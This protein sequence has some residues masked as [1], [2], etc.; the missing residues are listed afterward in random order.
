MQ[1]LSRKT[2]IR[3]PF[4]SSSRLP[5]TPW[6]SK[7]TK[8]TEH[9]RRIDC[10]DLGKPFFILPHRGPRR[11][12]P[13]N[14]GSSGRLKE[15]PKWIL[16]HNLKWGRIP[17]V[18]THE[19]VGS[20]LQPRAQELCTL[21]VQ[22]DWEGHSM[23][24]MVAI[25]AGRVY[26]LG[27]LWVLSV[28]CLKLSLLLLEK[29]CSWEICLAKSLGGV[30]CHLLLPTPYTNSSAAEAAMLFS[31]ILPQWPENCPPYSHRGHSWV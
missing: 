26:G 18:R 6:A 10:P 31:G 28:D 21:N 1:E 2:E 3:R 8:S 15:S 4:E 17:L 16:Q 5:P 25:S 27:Q 29:N 14:S 23:K 22:A 13:T 19:W 12:L 9:E 20:V 30:Y 7:K 24:A 11:S